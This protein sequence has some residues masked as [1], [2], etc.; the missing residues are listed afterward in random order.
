[1]PVSGDVRAHRDRPRQARRHLHRR[2]GGRRARRRVEL[3]AAGRRGADP[4]AGRRRRG[5]GRGAFGRTRRAS[6]A[7][8]MSA[9]RW[10]AAPGPLRAPGRRQAALDVAEACGRQTV[11]DLPPDPLGASSFGAGQLI[12][13]AV[14]AGASRVIVGVGGTASTDGGEGLRQA[15]AG[16]AE[17]VELVAALD[18]RNP[19][20]GPGRGG[21]GIRPAEGSLARAGGGA[22]GAPGGPAAVDRRAARRRRGRRR[23]RDA[24]GAWRAPDRRRRARGAGR[25]PGRR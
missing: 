8:R 6:G 25:R 3:R 13:A 2:R 19:L 18:V 7:P 9:T 21:G 5:H 10:A 1:M 12:A 20:L 4:P 14:A 11:A 24:L 17:G 15:L 23:R 16:A 22:R